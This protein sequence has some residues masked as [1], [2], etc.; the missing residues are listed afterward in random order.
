MSIDFPKP[1]Y[2]SPNPQIDIPSEIRN[3]KS[4]DSPESR[5]I[6]NQWIFFYLTS[7]THRVIKEGY[8]AGNLKSKQ[9]YCAKKNKHRKGQNMGVAC[10]DTDEVSSKVVINAFTKK[11]GLTNFNVTNIDEN[12]KE[13]KGISSCAKSWHSDDSG[14]GAKCGL[15][16]FARKIMYVCPHEATTLSKMIRMLNV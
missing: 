11:Q 3:P 10:L 2:L 8:K 1:N 6:F 14:P 12:A 13:S 4:V 9:V 7:F 15:F 16:N 5:R